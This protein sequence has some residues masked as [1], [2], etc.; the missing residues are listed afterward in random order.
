MRYACG[1]AQKDRSVV[2]AAVSKDWASLK[3]GSASLRKDEEVEDDKHIIFQC[4]S[5]ENVV[6]RCI[7]LAESVLQRCIF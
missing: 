4:N 3:H 1:A 2:L 6:K 7:I 5:S